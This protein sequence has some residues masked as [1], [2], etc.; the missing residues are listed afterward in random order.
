[1]TI[2]DNDTPLHY[3]ASNGHHRI[4]EYLIKHK[5]DMNAKN[6]VIMSLFLEILLF[7]ML[8]E[9]ANLK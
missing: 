2:E 7:I 3:A 8:P 1:L 6:H 4:I 5:A 9:M